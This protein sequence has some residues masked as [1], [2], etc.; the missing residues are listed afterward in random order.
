MPTVAEI[1]DRWGISS[2]AV[3]NLVKDGM[4]IDSWE[5]AEAWRASRR[6]GV[7][8][9]NKRRMAAALEG[10]GGDESKLPEDATDAVEEAYKK[11]RDIVRFSRA[12]YLRCLRRDTENRTQ[13]PATAKAY[14][15]YDKALATLF[16]IDKER[17]AR[18]LAARQLVTR[19]TALD[20]FRKVLGLVPQE[21]EKAETLIA[22]RANPAN[23]AQALAALKAFR[24]E[25]M[26]KIYSHARDAAASITG[27]EVGDPLIDSAE[28]AGPAAE[29]VTLEDLVP[30]PEPDP[31][32]LP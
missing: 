24:L 23:P 14:A 12:E 29:E 8:W 17:T 21:W 7:T 32:P 22:K 31:E 11:Q 2:P 20:R 30:D 1:A 25:V 9:E 3:S 18:A 26:G 19:A 28:P 5:A 6:G 4:P 16:K 27:Q 10:R 13:S 15:T